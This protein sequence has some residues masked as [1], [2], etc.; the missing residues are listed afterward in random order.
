MGIDYA[1]ATPRNTFGRGTL[2]IRA[3]F[4]GVKS[5]EITRIELRPTKY[6]Y[7]ARDYTRD[8]NRRVYPGPNS[9]TN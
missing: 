4:F 8:V 1:S 6:D 2:D 9:D 7:G 3:R 5:I